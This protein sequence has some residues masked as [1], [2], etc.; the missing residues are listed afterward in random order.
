MIV[1]KKPRAKRQV[2]TIYVGECR[3]P[4][5][6]RL[7]G[8]EECYLLLVLQLQPPQNWE[9]ESNYNQIKTDARSWRKS[10]HT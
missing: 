7:F 2:R 6:E 9:W 8:K 4:L 10:E 1:T 5:K 3:G